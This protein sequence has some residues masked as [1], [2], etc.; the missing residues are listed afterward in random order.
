MNRYIK[1]RLLWT[2][3]SLIGAFVA[4]AVESNSLDLFV[5]PTRSHLWRTSAENTPLI[6][7]ETP[8]GTVSATLRV[9]SRSGVKTYD[10]TGTSAFELRLETPES[11]DTENVYDLTLTFDL[12]ASNVVRRGQI[13]VVRGLGASGSAGAAVDIRPGGAEW[14]KLSGKSAVLQL[15]AGTK[16]LAIDG[17]TIETGLDGAAGWYLWKGMKPKSG[18]APYELALVTAEGESTADV[19]VLAKGFSLIVR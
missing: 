11:P 14:S 1:K 3:L 8:D 7:W 18:R 2:W 9:D 10:V 17:T 13:G 12:G 4:E 6:Q 5:D 15:P 16:T 19:V